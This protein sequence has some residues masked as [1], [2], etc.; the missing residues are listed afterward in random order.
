[1]L[2]V[3]FLLKHHICCRDFFLFSDTNAFRP[4]SLTVSACKD[5]CPEGPSWAQETLGE[6][7][8]LHYAHFFWTTLLVTRVY[9]GRPTSPGASARPREGEKD[10]G[11]P[12]GLLQD[13]A[14]GTG[15]AGR[16]G[17]SSLAL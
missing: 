15:R 16:N 4:Q 3:F 9:A 8:V 5:G 11:E 7:P 2:I 12:S 13:G 14:A 17:R 6:S 1:M 10:A